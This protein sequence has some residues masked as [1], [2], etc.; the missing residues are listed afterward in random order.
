MGGGDGSAIS[1]TDFFP[2]SSKLSR[3]TTLNLG[4]LSI[5]L[6]VALSGADANE[7]RGTNRRPLDLPFT[8]DLLRPQNN[9][10]PPTSRRDLLRSRCNPR[11]RWDTHSEE[12]WGCIH[13]VGLSARPWVTPTSISGPAKSRL[14]ARSDPLL[15]CPIS[16]GQCR[17]AYLVPTPRR[18]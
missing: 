11:V 4:K 2:L 12:E 10:R 14:A 13:G 3:G 1:S 16:A 18:S 7:G 17:S 9:T 5:Q 6:R 15:A 8:S